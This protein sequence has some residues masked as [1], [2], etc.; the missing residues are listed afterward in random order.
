MEG[1]ILRQYINYLIKYGILNSENISEFIS[2]YQDIT[3]T[4]QTTTLKEQNFELIFKE[5]ISQTFLKF[6]L[7]LSENKLLQM[8][9]NIFYSFLTNQE[10]ALTTSLF[11][12]IRIYNKSTLSKFYK[13]KRHLYNNTYNNNNSNIS[14]FLNSTVLSATTSPTTSHRIQLHKTTN[15]IKHNN[16]NSRLKS[17][18]RSN[19]NTHKG[20]R[21]R[22]QQSKTIENSQYL[23]EQN[24][25]SQCTFKPDLKATFDYYNNNVNK[26][27][28][29][30]NLSRTSGNHLYQ[31]SNSV[32]NRLYTEHKKMLDR[33][34]ARALEKSVKEAKTAPFKPKFISSPPK[35]NY[36]NFIERL[37]N[38]ENKKLENRERI[39][40]EIEHDYLDKCSFSP[41][42]E[43]SQRT[44]TRA[45]TSTN[46]RNNNNNTT[47]T[48]NNRNLS[49][50]FS[51]DKL[52]AYE[53]LYEYNKIQK[54]NLKRKQQEID[55]E[56]KIMASSPSVKNYT[57]INNCVVP[58]QTVD[59]K[60]IESLYNDYKRVK[61]KM[62]QKR[63]DLDIEQGITFK[64]EMYTNEKYYDKI[65][66]DF[67]A[68]ELQFME[69]KRKHVDER[70][71]E[72]ELQ[73]NEQRWGG[74][75]YSNKEKEE[76][77][78]NI[79]NRLYKK[80]LEKYSER[81]G[82]NLNSQ[83]STLDN[84]NYTNDDNTNEGKRFN[85]IHQQYNYD[86]NDDNGE[87]IEY[88]K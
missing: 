34:E 18:P 29:I 74:G 28:T 60:K 81:R 69:D 35:I 25:L 22:K 45:Y 72:N 42:I 16:N 4:I 64:P 1:K 63:N 32:H 19:I 6:I 78:N 68:R 54:Q 15:S 66:N 50:S 84:N 56:I 44:L 39:L 80:G 49:Q 47:T 36:N 65:T 77:T 61:M 82:V 13:W 43:K 57:Q 79:I 27:A 11:K 48:N 51:N 87:S 3:E 41:N 58:S 21:E 83:R 12:V 38:F 23:K 88:A 17:P 20:S 14:C 37:K 5:K 8:G 55:N 24:E 9:I 52:P 62:Q 67:H 85:E 46:Y 53:R 26:F 86:N 73:L 40:S 31:Q 70:I 2:V 76:I 71:Q 30:N 75:K 33:R 7:S 59:Y 10:Q